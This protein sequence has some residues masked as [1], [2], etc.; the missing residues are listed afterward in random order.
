VLLAAGFAAY[1]LGKGEVAPGTLL[2]VATVVALVVAIQLVPHGPPPR[3]KTRD[4][5]GCDQSAKSRDRTGAPEA[6]LFSSASY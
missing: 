3:P 4:G 5:F 1:Q 2:V 6:C